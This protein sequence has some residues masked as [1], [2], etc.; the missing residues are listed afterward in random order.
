MSHPLERTLIRL[1]KELNK[2]KVSP[3][4]EGKM[5]KRE[6][7]IYTTDIKELEEEITIIKSYLA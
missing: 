5:C 2:I 1:E 4:E 6:Y 7:I 3:A